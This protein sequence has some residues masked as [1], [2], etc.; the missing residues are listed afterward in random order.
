[1]NERFFLK[2]LLVLFGGLIVAEVL[3]VTLFG[4][5]LELILLCFIIVAA[6][7]GIL[8]ISRLLFT[9]RT[10]I[11]T[12]SMRRA[13]EK[14]TGIIQDRL[15]EYSVDEEFLRGTVLSRGKRALLKSSYTGHVTNREE[16]A[17]QAVSI[18]EA[19]RV[20]AEMYGGLSQ[21]L[22]MIEKID[23]PSFD[24]LVKKLGF[25]GV[26]RED[27]ILKITLMVN[28]ESHAVENLGEKQCALEGHTMDRGSF[29]EY[30]RRCMNV[31]DDELESSDKGFSVELDSAA[32]SKGTGTVPAD[33]SHDPK[34]VF[35]KLNKSGMHS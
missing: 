34:A 7:S 21:L 29:D 35:S 12:V 6:L 30:I 25:G 8:F 9:E 5:K 10:D 16:S 32:L 2:L 1:M 11:D 28:C 14:N 13:K 33:F 26:S 17:I 20:H 31:A 19:I 23:G 27:M 15:K 4:L 18:E 24:R 22:Q 3:I